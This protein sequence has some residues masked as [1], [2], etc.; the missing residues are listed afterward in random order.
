[1]TLTTNGTLLSRYEAEALFA[2]G[3]RRV[4]VSLDSLEPADMRG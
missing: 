4:N 2:T 1:M 3:V